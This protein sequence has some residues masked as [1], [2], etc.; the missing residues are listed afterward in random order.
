MFVIADLPLQEASLGSAE[1]DY[2]G[3]VLDSNLTVICTVWKI[4]TVISILFICTYLIIL[5]LLC[6]EEINIIF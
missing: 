5:R 1:Y 3:C 6:H 4:K 2:D